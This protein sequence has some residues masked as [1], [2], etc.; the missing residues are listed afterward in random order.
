[1]TKTKTRILTALALTTA[2]TAPA[3]I[4][5]MFSAPAAIAAP[6]AV[7][8]FS[9]LAARVTPAVVNVAV[10]MKAGADDGDE[11]RMSGPQDKQMEEFMKRFTERFGQPARPD[12]KQRPQHKGQAVGTGFIVDAKGTIVTNYHVVSKA[13]SITVTLSDGTKLPAKLMGGDEKTDLAVL[14]V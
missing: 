9:D 14:K 11:V 3:L 8:D 13:D 12:G 2:L 7:Q 4:A 6:Q 5:P 10:T 1:M